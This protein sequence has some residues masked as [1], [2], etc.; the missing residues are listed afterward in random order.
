M[1]EPNKPPEELVAP[2][3]ANLLRR[4]TEGSETVYDMKDGK[5]TVERRNLQPESPAAPQ[6]AE[7]QARAHEFHTH[8]SL[9]DYLLKYGSDSTVVYADQIAGKIYAVLHE[10][11]HED[12]NRPE[13]AR[14]ILTCVPQT[15]P[16]WA[17]WQRIAGTDV[18]LDT[19]ADL[20][21]KHR[22]AIVKPSG[23]DLVFLLSQ[24]RVSVS[25][26]VQKGRGRESVNGLVVTTSVEPGRQQ[27][28][29]VDFPETLTV[30]AP[31][32][33]GQIATDVELDLTV[34]ADKEGEVSVHVSAGT[35]D[36]ARENGFRVMVE[37]LRET[38]KPINAVV[39][40]GKPQQVDWRYLPRA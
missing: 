25:V 13:T 12:G 2:T 32:F 24:I 31:L 8:L 28:E 37:S 22:R 7:A 23:R 5:L 10:H 21:G 18:D 19:F 35:V 34:S 16:L 27:A 11:D 20:V 14:E 17:P 38:L 1:N 15:H 3:L 9:S 39:T 33:V 4:V 26:E 36:E 30:R 29:K 40:M 6:H